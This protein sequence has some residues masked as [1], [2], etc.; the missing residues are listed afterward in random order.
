MTAMPANHKKIIQAWKKAQG[1]HLLREGAVW[2]MVDS[3]ADVHGISVDK[4][5]PQLRLKLCEATKK[6]K[7]ATADERGNGN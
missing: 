1:A 5:C 4:H 2:A 6:F 7:C 3:S